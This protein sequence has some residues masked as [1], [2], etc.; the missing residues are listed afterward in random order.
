MEKDGEQLLLKQNVLKNVKRP[1]G[2][3]LL[4][5]T[6]S[7]LSHLSHLPRSESPYFEPPN[8]TTCGKKIIHVCQDSHYIIRK[9]IAYIKIV[10]NL[11]EIYYWKYV[12]LM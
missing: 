9:V 6:V 1:P 10:Q 12:Q 4:Y 7:H 11:L 8:Y 3:F 2:Q 5:H